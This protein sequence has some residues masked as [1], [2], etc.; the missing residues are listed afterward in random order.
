LIALI[1]NLTSCSGSVAAIGLIGGGVATKFLLNDMDDRATHIV[2]N[3]AAAGSLVSS[4]V[5]RDLQLLIDAT[6]Q[7]FHDELDKQWDRLDSEKISVLRELNSKLEQAESAGKEFGRL[8]DTVYLDTDS[9]V[10]RIPFAQKMPR[11]RK[12][13]GGSQYFK[14]D[15]TY[16]VR[17]TANI[18]A[19]F[20]PNVRISV[21][22]KPFTNLRPE[23]PYST[24]LAIGSDVL[25]PY[26]KEFQ[27]SYVP[28]T[29]STEM[30]EGSFLSKKKRPFTFTI[31]LEL[32][33]KYPASYQ[34]DQAFEAQVVD[35]SRVD[36]APG[37]F[38]TIPGCG[39]SGCNAYWNVCTNFPVGA[40]P[41]RTVNLVDTFNGWGGFGAVTYGPS[42]ACQV[43][44]Q[45]SHN[46][47]RNVKIDVEYHP[48][49]PE[50]QHGKI[51]LQ[52]IVVGGTAPYCTALAPEL[53]TLPIA[54]D[55]V[56][57]EGSQ[58]KVC[59]LQFGVTYS[60]QFNP[61]LKGYT[62]AIKT[63]NGENYAST[64][65]ST[66]SAIEI[67]DTKETTFVRSTVKLKEPKW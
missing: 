1:A 64:E 63:F 25:N 8:E 22:D 46:V 6:R 7:N 18:L 57:Q 67:H 50:I 45:H 61:A 44:W 4:K 51:D 55:T 29:I 49:K 53:K 65:N 28:I 30:E 12:V 42:Q 58:S 34:L 3:A 15:G 39:D 10:S 32:F 37:S 5:A 2:Q 52:P 9:L 19:P 40:Q 23:P 31:P 43:Y 66:D 33:P 24:V 38:M 21:A 36:I 47:A 54:A 59:W 17:I 56:Q 62:L 14:A 60:A 48:L 26:F 27:L 16:S 13:E 20:G 41:T 11:I 35:A